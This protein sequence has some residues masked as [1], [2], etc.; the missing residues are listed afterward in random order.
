MPDANALVT[1]ALV[2]PRGLGSGGVDAG[3]G[4]QNGESCGDDRLF[5][6]I[7][8]RFQS[9]GVVSCVAPMKTI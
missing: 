5:H 3:S 2:D 7:S 9:A 4:G 8:F 1:L 6:D